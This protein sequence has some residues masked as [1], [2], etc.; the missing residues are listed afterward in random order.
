MSDSTNISRRLTMSSIVQAITTYGPISRASVAKMTGYSKQTVSE[1]VASLEQDGWVQTVGR[2]EGS[3]GRRA[4]VY[5]IVPDAAL[6]ASIDLGGTKVRVALCNLAGA[7]VA[8]ITEPT[9]QEGGQDV[10]D[11]I[12][13][14]IIKA[15]TENNITS[16]KVRVAVVGV[17]GV[18][19]AK[20][21]NIKFAPNI[22]GVDSIDFTGC[23]QAR[24]G[25]EVLVENDVNLA[26]LGEHWMTRQGERDDLVF[27]SI[28]TGI[29]AGLVIGGQLVRG[30]SGAAGEIG[31]I[32]FGADPY[33]AESKEI[34]ALERVTATRAIVEEYSKLSGTTK[35]VPEIFEA[36]LNG[37]K[38]AV[39]VL[40]NAAGYIARAIASIAAVVDPAC[41]IIGGSIGSRNE[42][43]TMIEAE[44]A[45]C[46]PRPIP[47]EASVL[48]N[49]AALAGGASIAL[50]RLHISL[51]SGGLAGAEII[52]PPPALK[53][54]Q[55]YAV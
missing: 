34:G 51:F 41:V 8:E 25:I 42:L 49:H 36:S 16:E 21:G 6:V 5:E 15:T 39:D 35:T 11:Q 46:F 30:A 18:L 53:T 7:V 1:I 26:A 43:L 12:A 3:V 17:P 13:R 22:R 10:V 52:I 48:G 20:T 50:S 4:V 45:R 28:G 44:I 9:T 33:E 54:Y 31:Y 55:E 23:L 14:I 32:P 29:G 19:D 38:I 2:T 40:R 24:L 27:L 37:D 47:I